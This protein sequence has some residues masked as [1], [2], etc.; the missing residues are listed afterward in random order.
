MFQL[1]EST[2]IQIKAISNPT[3][4][5]QD[6]EFNKDNTIF[7]TTTETTNYAKSIRF[8]QSE[9]QL[10]YV[11]VTG[12]ESNIIQ[13]TDNFANNII[14]K[15]DDITMFVKANTNLFIMCIHLILLQQQLQILYTDADDPDYKELLKV[16]EITG[17]SSATVFTNSIHALNMGDTIK[18]E[19]CS[20]SDYNKTTTV[21]TIVDSFTFT[22]EVSNGPRSLVF[23]RYR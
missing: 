22:Y 18:I 12:S 4:N 21:Q 11:P 7:T 9:N 19:N 14:L 2:D 23:A 6:L 10:S 20:Q 5:F 15:Q 8:N 16:V 13:G 17:G 3:K 1:K